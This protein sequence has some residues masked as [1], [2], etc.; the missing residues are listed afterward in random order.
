MYNLYLLL[1]GWGF[2][3]TEYITS[4]LVFFLRFANLYLYKIRYDID[5]HGDIITLLNKE[6]LT[7]TISIFKSR[8]ISSGFF[9]NSK[10]IGYINAFDCYSLS[11]LKITIITTPK[12]FD[13]LTKRKEVTIRGEHD[14]KEIIKS[15]SNSIYIYNRYGSYSNFN[16]SRL[17]L[18]L[19]NLE[20]L[21]CQEPVLYEIVS[22]YKRKEQVVVFIEGVP[23]SGKSSI[24]YLVAKQINA[25]FCHTFNPTVPGDNFN[26][27][28]TQI[29]EN[30]IAKESPIVV[31]LEEIDILLYNIHHNKLVEN[32]KISISVKDKS[33]WCSFL[34]DMF[35]YQNIVLIMTSNKSKSEID[36]MDS[37]YLRK[38]RVNLYFTMNTPIVV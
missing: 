17:L 36:M 13:Y 26:N 34:D 9:V 29:R 20:P 18:N 15:E 30:D 10:S 6:V 3:Q 32:P 5:S 1:V 8:K 37:A 2:M 33:S 19:K 11:D 35:L 24:G 38:G 21:L 12:Y 23:C 22:E 27:L 16:Y 7:S 14:I 31:V 28:I 4:F 25:S